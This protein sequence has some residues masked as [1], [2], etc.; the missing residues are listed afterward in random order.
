MRP[1]ESRR[2]APLAVPL[3][4]LLW[5]LNWPAVRLCLVEIPPWTLRTAGMAGAGV[6]LLAAA[7]VSGR[8]LAVPRAQLGRLLATGLLQLAAFN[9]LLAFAQLQAATGRAAVVT[10]TMPVWTVLLAWPVLGERPDRRRLLGCALGLAGL[11]LLAGPLWA[12]GRFE[13]GLV[14]AL[15]A[16]IAWAAGTVASKRW[17]IDAPALTLAAWQLLIGALGAGAGMLLFEGPPVALPQLPTTAWAFAYHLLAAQALAYLLWFAVLPQLSAG[18]ATLGILPVPAVGVWGAAWLLGE[19]VSLF[20]L[21][22]LV[23]V[24]AAAA[25][26]LRPRS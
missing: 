17:P 12:A 22:G 5:G 7:A 18:T 19:R 25:T 26:I 13:Q 2:W 21:S 9:V 3:L 11:G 14:W 20:D 6:C 15:L 1:V 16:G 4:S 23:C 10:F 24:L 8:P